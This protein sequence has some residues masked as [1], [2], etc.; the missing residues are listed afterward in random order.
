M[1][2]R[3]SVEACPRARARQVL[4]LRARALCCLACALMRAQQLKT[5]LNEC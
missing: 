2:P 4:L 1:P 5:L 3:N